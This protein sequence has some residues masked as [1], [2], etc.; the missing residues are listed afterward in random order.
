MTGR[1]LLNKLLIL[2]F[3]A[4]WMALPSL[5]VA[6]NNFGV[7]T[8]EDTFV[9]VLISDGENTYSGPVISF[10]QEI[11]LPVEIYNL[12]GDVEKAPA[13][14]RKII[15]RNPSLIFALG[16]KAAVTSKIWT[17][18]HSEIPVIFAMVLNW[19]RFHLLEG[20]NNI[21]G[22]A[23]DIAP[24]THLANL[25]MI[26]PESNRVGIIYNKDHT[27]YLV[28]SAR[29]S[30]EILGL[31]IVARAIDSPKDFKRAF[32]AMEDK[33]DSYWLMHDPV[34]Y[35]FGN[36]SWLEKRCITDRIVCLGPSENVTK[37]GV[38]LSVDPDQN[39][40]GVQAAS[41]GKSILQNKLQPDKIGVMSPLG[42]RLFINLRTA[43]KIDL[44]IGKYVLDQATKVI[45]Q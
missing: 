2:L 26:S 21:A 5:S 15:K 3:M 10:T 14:M 36:I 45:M 40:I 28:E 44:K 31:K 18:D 33:I 38:V 24:G 4:V 41:I 11:N 16:A 23:Y 22:I 27:G 29:K 32:K 34:V 9:A 30:A 12:K 35:T 13:I 6:D 17:M 42:T 37:L 19:E 25:T 20:Q 39:N 43:E 7:A 8:N 1:N